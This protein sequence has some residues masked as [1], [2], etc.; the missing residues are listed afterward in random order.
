M[1]ASDFGNYYWHVQTIRGGVWLMADEIEIS[2][3]GVLKCHGH[4]PDDQGEWLV[5]AFN[6]DVWESFSPASPADGHRLAVEHDDH[7]AGGY[8]DPPSRGA[9]TALDNPEDAA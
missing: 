9:N 6:R 4:S 1:R 2:D 3:S 8:A 7:G 5:M